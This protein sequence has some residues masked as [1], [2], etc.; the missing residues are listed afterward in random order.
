MENR[1]KHCQ[2]ALYFQRKKEAGGTS[3]ITSFYVPKPKITVPVLIKGGVMSYFLRLK[4]SMFEDIV[5]KSTNMNCMNEHAL[6]WVHAFP[7]DFFSDM[8]HNSFQL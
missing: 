8:S 5:N 4:I 3:L 2:H 6:L 7:L 1:S